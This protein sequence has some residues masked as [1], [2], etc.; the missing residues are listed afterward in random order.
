M[1][2]VRLSL[3]IILFKHS[4]YKSWKRTRVYTRPFAVHA[5]RQ[6][7]SC[8]REYRT[9][10][11]SN[12]SCESTLTSVF[13]LFFI[14]FFLS[15]EGEGSFARAC[16][17]LVPALTHAC[18]KK[19]KRVADDARYMLLVYVR[20]TYNIV[21][22]APTVAQH[23]CSSTLRKIEINKY[24]K[25][26]THAHHRHSKEGAARPQRRS[27]GR[28]GESGLEKA[29]NRRVLVVKYR[30]GK[31]TRVCRYT[32]LWSTRAARECHHVRSVQI[33]IYVT[34]HRHRD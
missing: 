28:P 17:S 5:R 23:V 12:S 3:Y 6:P 30:I 21:C 22:S 33:L 1:Q 11:N 29:I 31:H 13:F 32:L 10:E 20:C 34:R 24:D 26:H 9:G 15:G 7:R 16:L 25:H 18:K 27:Y 14:S 2:H 19:K 8:T 4:L